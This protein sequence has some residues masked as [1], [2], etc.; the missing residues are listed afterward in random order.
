MATGGNGQYR[1]ATRPPTLPLSARQQ[2]AIMLTCFG[3]RNKEIARRMGVSTDTA[4]GY[5]YHAYGRLGV[6]QTGNPRT[7]AAL[8][9]LRACQRATG[10]RLGERA[11]EGRAA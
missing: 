4:K 11:R 10:I 1:W 8:Q 6:G 7:Q 5:L 3:L 9:L 2:E